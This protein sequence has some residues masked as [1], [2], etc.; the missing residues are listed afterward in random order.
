[1]KLQLV[2]IVL[3]GSAVFV[4]AG[5]KSPTKSSDFSSIRKQ[6]DTVAVP[7]TSTRLMYLTLHGSEPDYAAEVTSRQTIR[8]QVK[9]YLSEKCTVQLTHSSL[10]PS[11]QTEAIRL[12][13]KLKHTAV[14]DVELGRELKRYLANQDHQF[15]LLMV[16]TGFTCSEKRL[17]RDA[18]AG[19]PSGLSSLGMLRVHASSA[20]SA[21]HALV[22]DADESRV[23]YFGHLE[24]DNAPNDPD[25]LAEY[26]PLVLKKF[27]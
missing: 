8:D 7:I 1:M 9:A 27:M 3:V 23:I 16:Y 10:E 22:L 24:D 20:G 5:C 15:V 4:V 11:A 17:E 18:L 26:V 21:L 2:G 12:C 19:F 25:R 14:D 13:L 6:I